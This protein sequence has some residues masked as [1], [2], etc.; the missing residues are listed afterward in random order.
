MLQLIKRLDLRHKLALS[1]FCVTLSASPA[2][3]ALSGL[4]SG[5]ILSGIQTK[6]TGGEGSDAWSTNTGNGAYGAFQQRKPALVDIGYMNKDGSWNAQASGVASLQD[7]LNCSTCQIKGETSY[8]QKNWSYLQSSGATDYIGKTDSQGLVYN[9]SALLECASYFGASGCKSY[10]SGNYTDA[11]KAAMAANPHIEADIAAASETNS[12]AITGG[13]TQVNNSALA[14][15]GT[16]SAN[17]A[18][19]EMMTYCAKE[20]QQLMQQ[21]GEQEVDRQ[22]ALASSKEFGYT[23][24]DGNGILDDAGANGTGGK[25][26]GGL[27]TLGYSVRSCLDNLL[28]SISGI[29]A[30]FQ[31]PDLSG[32]LSQAINQACSMA[33]SQLSNTMQPLYNKVSELN[34]DAYVGGGGWMP[35]MQLGSAYISQGGSTTT[36]CSGGTCS[37]SV[38]SLGSLLNNDSSWYMDSSTA[39]KSVLNY[40]ESAGQYLTKSVLLG[41]DM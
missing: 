6:E 25:G 31:K 38:A 36:G 13:N 15:G 1:A 40:G 4:D 19:A 11:V 18:A 35:G 20:I 37:V 32:L 2:V 41:Q 27:S 21:A 5:S 23:L 34:N 10:I 8:L 33:Q 22:T 14:Q 30:F 17:A 12:S 16:V 3:A 28:S 29:G 39:A 26:F 7:Y 9:E 24:M